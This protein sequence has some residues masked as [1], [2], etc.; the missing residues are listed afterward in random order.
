[1]TLPAHHKTAVQPLRGWVL[2]L[3]LL[4]LFGGLLGAFRLGLSLGEPFPG[5]V[6]LWR[7]E[8][9]LFTVSY[10]TPPNWSGPSAGMRINDRILCIEGY[11]PKPD[12]AVYG[13]DPR[14]A[15]HPCP[16][17]GKNYA[18]IFRDAYQ[19]NPPTLSFFID[20]DGELQTISNVPVE[21]FS[22][23]LLLETLAPDFLL[24]LALL[25]LG[26]LVY[27]A[28]P[29]F[30]INLI[31]SL[32][33]MIASNFAFNSALAGQI[34]ERSF[35]TSRVS[36]VQIIPWLP[37]VG[38]LIFHLA[39]LLCR[40]GP[41]SAVFRII[42]RPYYFISAIFS[43]I[44]V[45]AYLFNDFEFSRSLNWAYI[46]WIALSWTATTLWTLVS[47]SLAFRQTA[48]RQVRMQTGLVLAALA[49][50]ALICVPFVGLFITQPLTFPYMQGL[51]YV[52]LVA[53]GLIAYAILRYQLFTARTQTLTYLLV[54]VVSVLTAL[55]V[56]LPV[57]SEFGFVPLLG[58]SL[59]AGSV[60]AGRFKTLNFLDR[61]LHR[62]EMD[63]QAATRFSRQIH[64]PQSADRLA[65]AAINAL[66][67]EME[68][69][70]VDLWLFSLDPIALDHYIEGR[71]AE[72][73]PYDTSL[74]THVV[75]AAGP[76]YADS[77]AGHAF[78]GL[79]PGNPRLQPGGIWVPL[80]NHDQALGLLYIGPRWT[81]E[82]YG[83]D[84]L[85]LIRML[86]V[87]FG[88]AIANS[89][90]VERLRMMQRLIL[91]AEENERYKIARELHDTVLQFLLVLTFG[92][93]G[94]KENPPQINAQI[95]DWQ[96]RISSEANRLR[97]LLN[98]LRTP[99]TLEQRGLADSL[100]HLFEDMRCQTTTLL[101]WEIDSQ[102]EQA[103]SPDTKVALYR[104]LREAVQNALKHARARQVTINLA[105]KHERVIFSVQDNGLGFDVRDAMQATKKGYSSLQD[106][107]IYIESTG[108]QLEIQSTPGKGTSL[109]GWTPV[110]P[111]I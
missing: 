3:M 51:P 65:E 4:T 88:L 111:D 19:S 68:A 91:Q 1:M 108:G 23:G 42:H 94:M 78:D 77:E 104:M 41:L 74:L 61:L 60:F 30:E 16:N 56:Y 35:E 71:I 79:L 48:Q 12:A 46:T 82:V 8:F 110:L 52:G 11:S 17:G 33:M 102:V 55:I 26:W 100:E 7:K 64:Q 73:A 13:L 69:D 105:V 14:Y 99:E 72:T 37:L 66:K 86:S 90:Q 45:I 101:E 92:L 47:L 49:L 63:Y 67:E 85:R 58:S 95:E 89:R 62:E 32:V 109:Q 87:Q 18:A 38:P 43:I 59:L 54:L 103:L 25:G 93:D 84:D 75:Q 5:F 96:G 76:I 10:A 22:L 15:K 97:D 44:G 31:F 70:Q 50:S 9:K 81:G 83:E 106:M 98:Y 27:R 80:A 28:N 21:R 24:G 107:C 20:R 39:G 2:M 57:G 6:L 29:K 40:S 36:M 53:V 34:T